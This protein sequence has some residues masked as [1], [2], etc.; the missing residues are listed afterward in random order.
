MNIVLPFI[1]TVLIGIPW[2]KLYIILLNTT[3]NLLI[4]VGYSII[5]IGG[6][7]GMF[8]GAVSLFRSVSH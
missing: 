6:L 1:V 4:V 2:T 7:V 8:I 3:N 5:Y